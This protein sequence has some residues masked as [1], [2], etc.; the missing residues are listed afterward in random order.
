MGSRNPHSDAL[1]SRGLLRHVTTENPAPRL[2]TASATMI[3][4]SW[5]WRSALTFLLHGNPR[6]HIATAI[7]PF[8]CSW[9]CTLAFQ[10]RLASRS[11]RNDSIRAWASPF[12]WNRFRRGDYNTALGHSG[13]A[14]Y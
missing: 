4:F 12:A 2:T 3:R 8:P 1:Q 6:G 11:G 5:L 9:Q 10:D 13:T 14:R 7:H